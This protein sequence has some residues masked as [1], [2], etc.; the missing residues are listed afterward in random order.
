MSIRSLRLAPESILKVKH[1]LKK[2]GFSS[3][4]HFCRSLMISRSTFHRFIR[5]QPVSVSI[6]IPICE[7]LDLDWRT[8]V[9]TETSTPI[10]DPNFIGRTG[11]I[12]DLISDPNFV[13]RA[14]AIADL[15]Q[16]ERQ[17]VKMVV[18]Q[19]AGG[20]G[21]TTL[22]RQY[23]RSQGFETVL[24]LLIGQEKANITPVESI[25]EEWLKRDLQEEPDK[26]F[27]VA[28]SR[29]KRQLQKRKIGILIDNL[30]PALDAQGQIIEPHQRYV[31][32]LR[33][34]SDPSLKSLTLITSRYRLTDEKVSVYHY[35]LPGLEEEAWQ[36]FFSKHQ[37]NI[38]APTLTDMHKAYGGNAKAINTLL[39]AIIND[40]DGDIVSYWQENSSDILLKIDLKN[41]IANQFNR[42]QS[43]DINAYNLLCRL[44]CYPYQDGQTVPTEGLLCLLWDVPENQRRRVI[45]L[46]VNHSLIES[47]KKE[48]WLHP[49]IKA[50]AFERL[51]QSEDWEKANH[52]AGEFWTQSVKTVDDGKENTITTNS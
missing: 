41:L 47:F 36:E 33:V 14:G 38:D 3:T 6:F 30:E 45:E 49:V 10:S 21:K 16:L 34:L 22:A 42:L 48:Y 9:E 20:V 25:V 43:L 35:F 12:A 2:I 37:I 11:V 4:D 28:L 15:Q 40:F 7:T 8:I 13:G 19:A 44:S 17:G 24:E 46:L 51:K 18:I 52:K 23:L 27:G 39:G 31:E 29:L 32:L 1:A 5:G 50:E 26:E